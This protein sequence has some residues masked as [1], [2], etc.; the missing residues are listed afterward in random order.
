MLKI[1][2][3]RLNPQAEKIIAEEQAGFR[4]GRSTTEQI[5]NLRILCEKYN[6][7]Q[8]DLY[9]VFIDFKEAFDRVW[10]EAL[11]ATMKIFNIN[12]NIIKVIESL[13]NK[14]TSAVFFNNNI[15]EWFR[16][17]VGVRQGCL[18]SPTLFNIFLERIMIDALE[19]HEGSVSI[20]GKTITN[21]R[22]ADDIDGIAGAEQ[23]LRNLISGLNNTSNKYGM[24]IS[25]E[26]T[27]VMTNNPNGF[28]N[29]IMINNKKLE[30]VN[31]FKY[32]G[33]IISDEGSKP[34]ILSRIAQTTA[35]LA[36]L[37]PIWNNKNISA[38]SKIRLMRSLVMAIFLYACESWT[39]KS[40]LEKKIQAMEMRCFRRLLG[41]S[42]KDHITN[43]EVKRHIERE[44][45]PYTV[46]D[47]FFIEGAGQV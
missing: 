7:H 14:A 41:I 30:P 32:L 1:I 19:H 2:L 4:P 16:T 28:V 42:F 6:Q 45:G 25:A 17:T 37:R 43:E 36:K 47:L 12:S 33:A 26:K 10:H 46:L 27:K 44:I 29:D 3:N 40:E 38:S 35:A 5:F 8:Q 15:G 21:L 23:E 39:L 34:E 18:L 31:S 11:W 9:H 13:Y 22:F 24:E 20:G